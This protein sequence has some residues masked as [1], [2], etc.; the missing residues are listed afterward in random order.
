LVAALNSRSGQTGFILKVSGKVREDSIQVEPPPGGSNAR[1]YVCIPR[2]PVIDIVR[3]TALG[4]Y[5][6]M[7]I[8][9]DEARELVDLLQHSSHDS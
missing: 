1:E 6:S 8:D 4:K 2:R 3:E 7:V 9:Q 5:R